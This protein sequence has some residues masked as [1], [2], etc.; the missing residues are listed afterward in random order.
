MLSVNLT[1]GMGVVFMRFSVH[2]K[3]PTVR[4]LRWKGYA[5][6][7]VQEPPFKEGFDDDC[8][9]EGNLLHGGLQIEK[10]PT[11]MAGLCCLISSYNK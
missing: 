1:L 7:S 3:A 10:R 4:G 9:G 6:R 11:G 8:G 5:E 2:E